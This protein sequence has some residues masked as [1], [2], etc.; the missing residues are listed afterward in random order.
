[1]KKLLCLL[2]AAL[3]PALM[4]T[5]CSEPKEAVTT[6]A[7]EKATVKENAFTAGI[8]KM[9]GDSE[10]RPCRIQIREEN[11]IAIQYKSQTITEA[12]KYTVEGNVLR[13]TVVKTGNVYVFN[14]ADGNLIYDE[15]A[16]NPS[17]KFQKESGVVN[18][19]KF[20]L[21]HTFEAR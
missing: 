7:V 9:D 12:G 15:A 14:I 17:A 18:G 11:K 8:Y 21:D 16:S 13:V 4:F 6:T 19:A 10:T 3:V 1:M 2:I 20:T 5:A